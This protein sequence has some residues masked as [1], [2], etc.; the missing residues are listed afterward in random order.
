MNAFRPTSPS[1][2]AT[3]PIAALR[4]ADTARRNQPP[5]SRAR[6]IDRFSRPA[7]GFIVCL[8]AAASSSLSFAQH[9]V[10]VTLDELVDGSASIVEAT[11]ISAQPRWNDKHNL[12]LT[13]YRFRIGRVLIDGGVGN[14]EFVVTQAGGTLDGE[15]HKLS[16]NP[17]LFVGER[18]VAF[19]EPQANHVF[20]PFM[21]GDQG[22][23]RI[24][25]D[26]VA[27]ALSGRQSLPLDA[28]I[29]EIDTRVQKRGNAP[30]SFH[31][32]GPPA[33]VTYPAKMAVPF[34]AP[35]ASSASSGNLAPL[36][37]QASPGPEPR[38]ALAEPVVDPQP[39]PLASHA[40]TTP[41]WQRFA[42]A[43]RPIVWDE[44]P[45]DWWVSPHDQYMMST[46]NGIADNLN[47]VSG[48][49]LG[50]WAWGND[51]FEMVGFP[52]DADMISQFGSGWGAT[53]LAVT[54]SRW[55]GSGVIL[56]SD[57]AL[58]PAY[59]WTLDESQS[60]NGSDTCWGIDQST[61]HELGHAWGLAHP[62][63][64][65]DVWWDSVMNYAPKEFRLPFL[66]E[67]DTDAARVAYPGATINTDGLLSLYQTED[68]ASSMHATYT[69]AFPGSTTIYHGQSL[70][71]GTIQV[72][73]P[74]TIAFADPQV[75]IYLAQNWRSWTDSYYF[76][77]TA[78]YSTT[79]DPT[80]TRR[81]TVN[82]TTIPDTMPTGRYYPSIYLRLAG[83]QTTGNNTAA[84]SPNVTA[85]IH[86]VAATLEPVESW[87][88]WSL[89]RI[90]P[91][92]SWEL[93]LPVVAGDD[94]ELSLCGDLGGGSA[95]FDT[96]LEVVGVTSNDDD[97]GLASHVV[98]TSDSTATRTI[99]IRGYDLGAQGTFTLAYRRIV[100]DTLFRDGFD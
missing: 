93:L 51:R 87:R 89:G 63:E 17:E 86:N 9:H 23:Y 96:V 55:N 80:T 27:S 19:L 32:A 82:Q 62:W 6:R 7:L 35:L 37:Q 11:L 57:I 47:R 77:R 90:G 66:H 58:N 38:D 71:L 81:L 43:S 95:S 100:D 91:M 2:A 99:S 12:I 16:S 74:G 61:L 21:G 49:E 56:E 22:V 44:W 76:L 85:T 53:T 70:N 88:T 10:P 94:Y 64:S 4:R 59:C 67:D 84:S 28:L 48:A 78:S 54:W 8:W 41:N 45:H 46:W 26:N 79:V 13:D 68:N 92:G 72:E 42:L 69:S 15:T 29:A 34:R 60:A 25:G 65:Q 52:S 5:A 1:S 14:A 83:D 50:T 33:G 36:Q 20:C 97:C 75:E 39:E 73:N 40:P 31:R 18:Y 98:F 3:T 30:P 24:T